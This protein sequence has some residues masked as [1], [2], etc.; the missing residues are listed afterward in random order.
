MFGFG[1]SR[2]YDSYRDP[3]P[4]LRRLF[5]LIK[6]LLLAVIL[7]ELVTAFLIGSYK[8]ESVSMVPYY[9]PG[10][11][12]FVSP[13]AYGPEIPFSEDH[14]PG[15]MKPKRGDIVLLKTSYIAKVSLL[16][17]F[18]DPLKRFFTFQALSFS[19]KE[20]EVWEN[21]YVVKR[22]IALPGDSV[23]IK[24]QEALVKPKGTP[25]FVS[26]FSLSLS[27]YDI[28]KEPL[29]RDWKETDPFGGYTEDV[30]LKENEYYV[31]GDNRT[32]S[33]DSRLWGPVNENQI[34]GLVL[35][36][37]WPFGGSKKP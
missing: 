8:I 23:R 28:L 1:P 26:E 34:H 24:N 20:R 15:L 10:T 12:V 3:H 5:R 37:Y 19:L 31:L 16:E 11:R 9:E 25:D 36:R 4:F 27:R 17:S 22:I 30:T 18:L 2:R 33:T 32:K 7:Y 29:P 6:F 14:F 13:L 21:A 35:F